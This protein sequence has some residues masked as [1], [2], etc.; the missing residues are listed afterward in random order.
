VTDDLKSKINA[1]SGR[2]TAAKLRGV[3]EDIDRKVREGV[4]H[5]DIVDALTEAG[6]EVSLGTF[7][8]NL[9]R[10]RHLKLVASHQ[11]KG[12]PPAQAVP[13][14]PLPAESEEDFEAA[15]D[16]TQRQAT[17]QKYTGRRPPILGQ[18]RNQT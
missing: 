4:R 7:R 5:Q 18:K 11:Q 6:M 12:E 14:P 10:Y 13:S 2:S 15:L 8:M 17:T 3:M 1:L 16:P 9:Y